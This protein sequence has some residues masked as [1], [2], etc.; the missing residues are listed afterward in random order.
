MGLIA[1]PVGVLIGGLIGGII[2]DQI[3]YEGIRR[4]K[5][6]EHRR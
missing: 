3:E 1:G 6:E 5:E 4:E 2:G